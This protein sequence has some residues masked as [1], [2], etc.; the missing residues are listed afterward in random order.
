MA[1]R[2]NRRSVHGVVTAQHTARFQEAAQLAGPLQHGPASAV[3]PLHC[4][5]LDFWP[6][7]GPTRLGNGHQAPGGAQ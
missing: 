7:G 4:R 3:G 5:G 6:V 2:I 1:R